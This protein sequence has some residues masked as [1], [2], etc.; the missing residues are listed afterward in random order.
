MKDNSTSSS[1]CL[2]LIPTP[3]SAESEW[4]FSRPIED[5]LKS[6]SMLVC[7]RIRTSRRSIKYMFDQ[8]SFDLLTFVEMNKH[9]AND[10]IEIAKKAL[11]S[12]KNVSVLSEAGMPCVADPGHRLVLE[13]HRSNIPVHPFTGPSSFMLALMSSGL[14][15]QSFAFHGYL[16]RDQDKLNSALRSLDK[17]I[18]KNGSSQIFMETPYRNQ[19]LFDSILRLVSNDTYLNVSMELNGQQELIKTKS[20]RDWKK[21]PMIFKDKLPAVF[22]LGQP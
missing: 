11:K 18:K 15:G 19:K 16:S 17:E 20:I 12:G 5:A 13:A 22:I 10:Y 3:L 6:S 7:E 2:Y 21:H 1:G 4:V 8:D 14:N 9:E